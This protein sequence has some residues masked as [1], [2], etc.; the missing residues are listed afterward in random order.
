M[1][2][3]SNPVH[4]RR[5]IPVPIKVVGVTY[6]NADGTDRQHII[7]KHVEPG[8]DIDLVPEP[9]N[10]YDSNSVAVVHQAGQL[11]YVPREWSKRLDV[12][13]GGYVTDVLGGEDGLSY[14][15]RIEAYLSDR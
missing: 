2:R 8:D 10:P 4:T 14:G 9:D 15:L 3:P 11:G 6:D 1:G 12:S 5:S 7:A 13:Q